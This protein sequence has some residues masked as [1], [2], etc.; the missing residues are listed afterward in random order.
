MP[1]PTFSRAM[2]TLSL[3]ALLAVGPTALAFDA[4]LRAATDFSRGDRDGYRFRTHV[5]EP[6]AA[7]PT[8]MKAEV[9]FTP[10][11]GGPT[12]PAVLLT[13]ARGA[14]AVYRGTVDLDTF[15]EARL[16]FQLPEKVVMEKDTDFFA[17]APGG[18]WVDAVDASGLKV[19]AR[20]DEDGVLDVVVFDEDRNWDASLLEGV[21]ILVGEEPTALSF[22]ETRQRW[23]APMAWGEGDPALGRTY[24]ASVTLL[25]AEG[26][27]LD[28]LVDTFVVSRDGSDPGVETV[29]VG[30]TRKGDVRVVVWTSSDV[31]SPGALEMA[32]TDSQTGEERIATTDDAPVYTEVQ[33]TAELTFTSSPAGATYPITATPLGVDGEAVGPAVFLTLNGFSLEEAEADGSPATVP[34]AETEDGTVGFALT[35]AE[36]EG[37]WTL[38]GRWDG[39]YGDG[40]K[41][42]TWSVRFEEPFEGPVPSSSDVE[43]EVDGTWSKWVQRGDGALSE[44]AEAEILTTLTTAK[45]AVVDTIEASGTDTVF[46]STDNVDDVEVFIQEL[47]A[48]DDTPIIRRYKMRRRR[49]R[50]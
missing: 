34:F 27:A 1:A 15:A 49:A 37:V 10:L 24:R 29:R 22:V 48:G 39:A 9:V 21:D 35:P 40:K 3:P 12:V 20:L 6:Y 30:S 45:G 4:E 46:K 7:A 43:L 36:K 32:L 19:R 28:S 14:R 42:G 38:H 44:G 16:E 33:A 2:F 17:L 41:P 47:A 25:D 13:Q 18:G 26:A 23:K 11:D 8:A 50:V 5:D 31:A